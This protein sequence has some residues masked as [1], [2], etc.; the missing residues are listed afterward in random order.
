MD[1]GAKKASSGF[2]EMSRR[3]DSGRIRRMR[4]GAAAND[5]GGDRRVLL[6]W[7]SPTT[8][9]AEIEVFGA[10]LR[11]LEA[12]NDNDRPADRT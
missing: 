1:E 10:I 4:L 3:T 7:H 12:E 9:V 6:R 8:S 5:N 11:E 2:I